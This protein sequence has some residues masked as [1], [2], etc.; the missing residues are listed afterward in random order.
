M[1]KWTPVRK[2]AV[3]FLG[4]AITYVALRLGLD[5]GPDDVNEAASAVVGLIFGYLVPGE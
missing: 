5:L 1:S 3:A 4:S 2:I